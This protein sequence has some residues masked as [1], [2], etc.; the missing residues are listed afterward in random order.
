MKIL[1]SQLRKLIRE[2]LQPKMLPSGWTLQIHAGDSQSAEGHS[3]LVV[4]K[5]ENGRIKGKVGADRHWSDNRCIADVFEVTGSEVSSGFG[6]TLY[7]VAIEW[8]TLNGLGLI[9]DR[10]SV[11]AEAERV[12]G[13][14][15]SARPDVTAHELPDGYCVGDEAEYGGGEWYFRRYT[16]DEALIPMLARSGQL[17]VIFDNEEENIE[18]YY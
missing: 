7:D 18:F 14:Y 17:K 3:M 4:L 11:S 10:S 13:K 8:A 2:A 16:K 5:N 12:W 6:P 1:E 9:A 15:L